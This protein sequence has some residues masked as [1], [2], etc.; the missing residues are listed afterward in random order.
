MRK[1]FTVIIHNSEYDVWNI[2]GKEHGGYNGEPKTWWLYYSDRLPEG[3]MPPL[4]SPH[5]CPYHNWIERHLWDVRITQKNTSKSKWNDWQFSNHIN[6]EM[7][8]NGRLVYE[9]QCGG[10]FGFA[11]GKVQYLQ[12]VLREHVF[13][14]FEPEKENGRKVYW[15]GLPGTIR[16]YGGFNIAIV[17]DYTC[18]LDQQQWWDELDR[19]ESKIPKPQG[20]DMEKI[21]A[22]HRSE[23]RAEGEIRWGD[24]LECSHIDW[25]R[26]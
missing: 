20:D 11:V 16:V 8:L 14:F 2:D 18:G 13:N 24:P 15:K 10:D 5:W 17:P 3:V 4:D 6:V 21:E 12:V 7:H 22:E 19:R 1:A 23:S 26:K 9:F 25:F